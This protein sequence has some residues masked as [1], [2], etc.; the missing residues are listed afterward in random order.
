MRTHILFILILVNLSCKREIKPKIKKDEKNSTTYLFEDNLTLNVDTLRFKINDKLL[1]LDQT[2]SSFKIVPLETNRESLLGS[3]KKMIFKNELVYIHDSTKGNNS[4]LVFDLS[5]KHISSLNKI[6]KGPGEYMGISNFSVDEEG[7]IYVLDS[8]SGQKIL[9]YTKEGEHINDIFLEVL[10][11]DFEIF[12]E[13]IY[14]YNAGTA[15]NGQNKKRNSI[16]VF[17]KTGEIIKSFFPALNEKVL[18][19]NENT[20]IKKGEY[21]YVNMPNVAT[22]YAIN[23]SNDI[24]R[25]TY[26]ECIEKDSEGNLTNIFEIDSYKTLYFNNKSIIPYFTY[27]NEFYIGNLLKSKNNISKIYSFEPVYD[28]GLIRGSLASTGKKMLIRDSIF[29]TI[30]EPYILRF[31]L[32]KNQDFLNKSPDDLVEKIR[33]LKDSDNPVLLLST[34]KISNN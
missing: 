2:F 31:N 34:F 26:L 17:K 12:N 30:S 20:F 13:K 27:I 15:F 18:T 25:K 10:I 6:G 1:K 19:T 21:I 11:Y 3:P 23:K 22:L 28:K 33:N 9:K 24:V 29:V 14:G 4:I 5:G 32:L 8:S 16:F 7:N